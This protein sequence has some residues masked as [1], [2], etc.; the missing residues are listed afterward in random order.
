M[1]KSFFFW[2]LC[3]CHAVV[4]AA[5]PAWPAT[6]GCGGLCCRVGVLGLGQAVEGLSSWSLPGSPCVQPGLALGRAL[7]CQCSTPA[8]ISLFLLCSVLLPTW[9]PGSFC[10]VCCTT[11]ELKHQLLSLGLGGF[12]FWVVFYFFS[13]YFCSV[14]LGLP[15]NS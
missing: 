2:V 8:E 13:Q 3:H 5:I 11:W 7:W 6:P 12:F 9:L 15:A 1:H 4:A 14:I 10:S